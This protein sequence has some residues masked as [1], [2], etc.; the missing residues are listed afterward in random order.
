MEIKVGLFTQKLKFSEEV[1]L[2]FCKY[3]LLLSSE[4]LSEHSL[5]SLYYRIAHCDLDLWPP[6]SNQYILEPK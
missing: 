3:E 4:Q 1:F 2:L 6:E 5:K